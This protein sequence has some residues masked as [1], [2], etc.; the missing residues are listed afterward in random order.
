[1]LC[2]YLGFFSD[3]ENNGFVWFRIDS[4]LVSLFGLE[5][6]SIEQCC[7]IGIIYV[8]EWIY[9]RNE[10]ISRFDDD[11]GG[12]FESCKWDKAKSRYKISES[13]NE[14]LMSPPE[15]LM[16]QLLET[17]DMLLLLV[18]LSFLV[19]EMFS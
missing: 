19:R 10:T 8:A 11:G 4:P 13:N 14:N 1:M 6:L 7:C 12:G 2:F 3:D 5:N 16:D 15:S 17:S 18:F 9:G